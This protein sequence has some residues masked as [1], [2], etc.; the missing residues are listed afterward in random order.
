MV[1]VVVVDHRHCIPLHTVFLQFF[2]ALHHVTERR[3]PSPRLTVFVVVFLWAV[4]TYPHKP[5]VVTQETAPLVGYEHAIGL[6]AVVDDS[7]FCVFLLQDHCLF[8]ELQRSEHRL[9]AM[10]CEEN[11]RHCLA[12]NISLHERLQHIVGHYHDSTVAIHLLFPFIIAI[13]AVQIALRSCRLGHNIHRPGEGKILHHM[14]FYL[15]SYAFSGN[16]Y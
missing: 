3:L 1:S 6:Y 11:R 12:L 14:F 2:D 16:Y 8:V 13:S 10:P 4:D 9:S 5:S 15:Q 7:P